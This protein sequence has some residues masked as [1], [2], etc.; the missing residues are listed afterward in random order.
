MVKDPL[1][2]TATKES[3]EEYVTSKIHKLYNPSE[4]TLKFEWVDELP[5]DKNGKMRCFVCNVPKE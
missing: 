3:V 5:P 1:N 4:Y 2:K